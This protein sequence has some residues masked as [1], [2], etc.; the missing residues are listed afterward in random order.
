MK[1][2]NIIKNDLK[3]SYKKLGFIFSLLIIGPMMVGLMEVS[4]LSKDYNGEKTISKFDVAI[5]DE[6]KNAYSETLK[7]LF[8]KKDIADIVNISESENLKTVENELKSG[9]VSV[10]VVIPKGFSEDLLKG[11]PKNLSLLKAP[12][13]D[14]KGNVIE[15]ILKNFQEQIS[16][17]GKSVNYLNIVNVETKKKVNAS[18]QFFVTMLSA[19]M[20]FAVLIC[21]NDIIEEKQENIL[22]RIYSTGTNKYV[23]FYSKLLNVFLISFLQSFVYIILTSIIFKVDY[24]HNYGGLLLI[25]LAGSLAI[26]GFVA[27]GTGFFKGKKS[28]RGYTYALYMIMGV[29]SGCFNMSVDTLP[30]NISRFAPNTFNFNL[31]TAYHGLMLGKGINSIIPNLLV[32]SLFGIIATF[33]GSLVFKVEGAN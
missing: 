26:T 7:A 32:L 27:I 9:K 11:R 30:E 25:M 33:L 20:I 3:K 28:F 29:F 2:W 16:L 17:K 6:D 4:I 8:A 21:G 12:G 19:F 14:I 5:V 24:S 10:A 23:Y 18:Q 15:G 13:E 31:Y 1:A 22:F